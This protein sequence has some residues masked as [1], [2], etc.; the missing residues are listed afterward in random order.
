[1][2]LNYLE[3]NG[4]QIEEVTLHHVGNA[5]NGGPLKHGQNL[6]SLESETLRICL[7][8]MTSRLLS[9]QQYYCFSK[10]SQNEVCN[11]VRAIFDGEELVEASQAVATQLYNS[12]KH[13]N[14]KAGDFF[15]IRF[16]GAQYMKQEVDLLAFLKCETR[17]AFI[18]LDVN[19]AEYLPKILQGIDA[20]QLD[21]GF[22]VINTDEEKGFRVLSADRTAKA[23]DAIFWHKDFLDI[24]PFQ[25]EFLFTSEIMNVTND[26]VSKKVLDDF[27]LDRPE[28]LAL[29][30]KAQKYFENEPMFEEEKFEAA[31]FED[32]NMRNKYRQFKSE[33]VAQDHYVPPNFPINNSA[34]QTF[35]KVFKS[36][37]KLDK[38]FHIYVHGNRQYIERGFDEE[39]CKHY[40]KC[41]FDDEN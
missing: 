30:D 9:E 4:S 16:S 13:Q 33:E 26:F 37:I 28:Q 5:I 34:V 1:M 29:L 14:I 18:Q 32:T 11:A 6:L 22:L 35:S 21:K 38:N 2:A 36:V 24:V 19:D 12:G 15:C 17:K 27:D 40:Y 8:K 41:F 23:K 25:D 3:L 39:K 31:I 7:L 20:D 10:P